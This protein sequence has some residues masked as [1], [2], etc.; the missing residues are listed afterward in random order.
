MK[1]HIVVLFIVVYTSFSGYGQEQ[2]NRLKSLEDSGVNLYQ[3]RA[4]SKTIRVDGSPYVVKSFSHAKV[5]N[6]IQNA[7]L[8]YNACDDEF[9]FVS[10]SGDTLSLNKSQDFSEIAFTVFKTNF[11]LVNYTDKNG[12]SN[13]GYLIKLYDKN[14]Y[15]LYKRQKV[16]FYPAKAAKSSYD[17]STPARYE[18]AKDTFFLKISENEIAELPTNKKGIVKLFPEKKTEIEAFIKQNDIDIEK[19][20]DLIQLI[21]FISQ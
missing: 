5:G 15:I 6:V 1:K 21:G 12:R 11:Q 17:S 7:M 10:S 16:N 19:E 2:T 3:A 13:F 14:N 9:E 8:R 18:P 20:Q 4:R